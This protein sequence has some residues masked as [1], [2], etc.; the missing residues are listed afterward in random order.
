MGTKVSQSS[1]FQ[2]PFPLE[3]TSILLNSFFASIPNQALGETV[4]YVDAF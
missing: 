2:I 3:E 4:H 1:R